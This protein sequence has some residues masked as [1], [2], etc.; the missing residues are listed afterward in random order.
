MKH[1]LW[2][3]F[4]ASGLAF[5]NPYTVTPIPTPVPLDN[6][7]NGGVPLRLGDDSM[8]N[9]KPLGFD[10]TFYGNT[11]NQ[12]NISNNGL[13]TFSHFN[14]G[15]CEGQP[16]PS[17]GFDNTIFGLR[18]D[19][20]GSYNGNNPYFMT[21]GDE[22]N[23]RFVVGWYDINEYGTGNLNTFEISL[24]E[25]SNDILLNY[26]DLNVNRNFSAGI[27]GTG[28]DGIQLYYGTDETQLE[29]QSFC[30]SYNST[31]C[32]VYIEPPEP[33]EPPQ[34]PDCAIAPSDPQC[35]IDSI[36]DDIDNSV[37]VADEQ[38]L[39]VDDPE[40]EEQTPT[41]ETVTEEL[42]AEEEALEEVLQEES[43]G[44]LVDEETAETLVDTIDTKL[45]DIVLSVVE[46]TSVTESAQTTAVASTQSSSE[47][48]SE[49]ASQESSTEQSSDNSTEVAEEML[50]G[51]LAAGK[52]LLQETISASAE[53]AEVAAAEAESIAAVSVE[54]TT[55]ESLS[56]VTVTESTKEESGTQE[57]VVAENVTEQ[58]S[59]EQ[60]QALVEQ[61]DTQNVALVNE[62]Q[63]QAAETQTTELQELRLPVAEVIEN[64][65]Q[66]TGEVSVAVADVQQQDTTGE[67]QQEVV[68]E[69]QQQ[70]TK[71]SI[72][73]STEIVEF[74][75]FAVDQST[76]QL[77]Q[78]QL[79]MNLEAAGLNKE[80]EK[81]DAEI[82][83]EQVVAA[84]KEEQDAI[85]ANYMDADQS[86]IVVAIG[87]ETDV[88]SYRT[89]MVVDN[90]NW[91]RPDEIYKGV[92]IKDNVRNSYFLE[93]GNSDTYKKLIEEQY[94]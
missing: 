13:I 80:P 82:R 2:L 17:Q 91:Y 84:N 50:A 15:C 90:S 26:G 61:S 79:V 42:V 85:N 68:A 94:K 46:S 1:F 58:Q 67:V 86:G 6:I 55:T 49:T 74:V 45:L 73:D 66:Q 35:V 56:V 7:N 70:E 37:Y 43:I 3:L 47:Q 44:E 34:K 93:K 53:S 87:S 33:P 88:T 32:Q 77:N 19:L 9:W 8:S 78:I 63:Q 71:E 51:G 76:S 29:F 23:R 39:P 20:L 52:E 14:N 27:Q 48:Q 75:A 38:Q 18:T 5:A 62:A 92:I 59:V 60:E 57:T 54:K 28:Q 12:V 16:I 4:L 30:F 81:S 40:E 65:E 31:L 36:I 89:M 21:L 22:G 72:S 83:S 11:F 25:G 24:F 41:E 10:F 69:I 64:V